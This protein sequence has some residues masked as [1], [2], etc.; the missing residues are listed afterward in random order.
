MFIFMFIY[1][2]NMWSVE[3]APYSIT[4]LI[5]VAALGSPFNEKLVS[6]ANTTCCYSTPVCSHSIAAKSMCSLTL[7]V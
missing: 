2:D 1:S 6:T 5:F 7:G 3:C 4:G